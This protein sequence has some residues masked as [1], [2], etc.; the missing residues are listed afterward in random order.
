MLKRIIGKI[1]DI[2]VKNTIAR[3]VLKYH[4]KI[5]WRAFWKGLKEGN[6]RVNKDTYTESENEEKE[7]KKKY[8]GRGNQ[9]ADLFK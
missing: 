5:L 8:S 7:M 4:P 1:I 3:D 2:V 6:K 9:D